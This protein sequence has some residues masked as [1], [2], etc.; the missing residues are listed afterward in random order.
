MNRRQN[1]LQLIIRLLT[2]LLQVGR[3]FTSNKGLLL[4]GAV[5]Y[6]T[7][8]SI[9]PLSILALIV[10][11]Q[12]IEE[13]QLI[14]TLSTYLN[15]AV[16]GYAA[17]LTDQAQ[18]FLE[19]RK[20]VGIIGFLVMLFFSSVAFSTLENAMSVIFYKHDRIVRRK[21]LISVIIPYAYI[22]LMGLGIVLV[23]FIVGAIT[24]LENRHL[25][26]LGWSLHLGGATGVALSLLGIIGEVLILTS[27]YLV[28]PVVRVRFLHALI[29]G[30]TAT[31]LWEIT[32]RVLIWYYASVSMVNIIYGSIAMTVVALISIEF[33][34]V[35]LLLGA[36]V[37]VELERKS[38]ALT[39]EK[40]S[41]SRHDD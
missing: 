36:Q 16:P 30:L 17:T 29:G 14:L 15:M 19:N 11:T 39:G 20:V 38:D 37:I 6:Y 23:S 10:L 18:T 2:F 21:F 25:T 40:T 28:M 1:A 3:G 12:F 24:T 5:A 4:A 8:L 35:I 34:A 27:I 22:F 9:V 33:V 26:I 7:L 13:Q 31:V 41:G 32:R